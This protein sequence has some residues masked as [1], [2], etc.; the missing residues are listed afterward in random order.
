MTSS[1]DRRVARLESS[2]SGIG[3]GR[4][5]LAT[6]QWDETEDAAIARMVVDKGP[7]RPTDQV[8]VLRFVASDGN[9]G[10]AE[11]PA[12]GNAEAAP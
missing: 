6:Q 3:F 4:L 10:M 8:L 12:R 1:L 9:G 2:A 5:L 11:L 7:L